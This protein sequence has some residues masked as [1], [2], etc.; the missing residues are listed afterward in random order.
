MKY[1]AGRV[2]SAT[3]EQA[4]DAAWYHG[5]THIIEN[6]ETDGLPNWD[7]FDETEQD[8]PDGATALFPSEVAA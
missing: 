1:F 6:G 5:N 3:K 4:M 7:C 8:V 2:T